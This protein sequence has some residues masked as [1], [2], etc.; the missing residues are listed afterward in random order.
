[1]IVIKD[2]SAEIPGTNTHYFDFDHLGKPNGNICLYYGY[3]NLFN[4]NI[5]FTNDTKNIY[6]N[7]TMPTEFFS[8]QDIYLDDKFDKIYTI[9]PYSVDWL[10]EL[11]QTDKYHCIWYPFNSNHIPFHMFNHDKKFDICYHGGIHGIKYIEM[12]EI[13]KK[14]N[15][16]YMS[17]THGINPLTQNLLS[18]FATDLNLDNSEKLIRIAQCKISVC[19]NNLPTD[20]RHI[21]NATRLSDWEK[22]LAFKHLHDLRIA[23]QL[24]SRFIEAA[25]CKTLN[26]VEYDSWNVIEKWYE[27]DKDF[28]YF[29]GN[30]NLQSTIEW[31]LN[32][33]EQMQIIIENA[34][35]KSQQYS[36]QTL[37]E[38][39]KC[40]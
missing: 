31:A 13:I 8:D 34:Y 2:L 40:S 22:N 20:D 10:N 5:P 16:R 21:A 26:L 29:N 35:K 25:M 3:N 18:G 12:L 23:P 6:F 7:V 27:P 30:D 37:F 17:M 39:I 36:C 4:S 14:F 38:R 33:W 24:K 32:N 1:M 28:I 19:Y 9:C 15:Y 11:K